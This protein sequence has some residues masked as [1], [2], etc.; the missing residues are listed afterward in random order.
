VSP[1]VLNTVTL[2]KYTRQIDSDVLSLIIND[3]LEYP[4]DKSEGAAK[5]VLGLVVVPKRELLYG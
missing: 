1:R 4:C 5:D 3:F 2:K